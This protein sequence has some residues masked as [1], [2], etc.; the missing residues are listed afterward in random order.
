MEDVGAWQGLSLIS[1]VPLEMPGTWW[2]YRKMGFGANSKERILEILETSSVQ[3]ML[4]SKHGDRTGGQRN[5]TGVAM[6]D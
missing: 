3:K 1:L 6:G 4:L 2:Q 5:S